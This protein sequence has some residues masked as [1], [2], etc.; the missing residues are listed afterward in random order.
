MKNFFNIKINTNV[1]SG[2]GTLDLIPDKIRELKFKRIGIVVDG[3]LYD[4]NKIVKNFII[5]LNKQFKCIFHKYSLKFEPNY[6]YLDKII[7]Q[8]KKNNKIMVDCIIGIG[9]GSAM[10]TAKALAVI[11]ANNGN[12][13]SFRGFPTDLNKPLPVICVPTTTGTGSELVYNASIIDS[14]SKKKMGINDINNYPILAI[15]DPRLVSDAPLKVVISSTLDALVHAIESF[16]S[17]KSN[18]VTKI[19]IKE[20]IK[21]IF[22]SFPNILKKKSKIDDWINLQWA[23]YFAMAGLSNTSSGPTGALSYFLGANYSVPHGIAGGFF[24]KKILRFNQNKGYYGYAELYDSLPKIKLSKKRISNKSK[25]NE[26]VKYIEMLC[27]KSNIP[28][29]IENFGVK[30]NEIQNFIDF[31]IK[32]SESIK[33]NPVSINKKN[34]LNIIRSNNNSL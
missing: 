26:V 33:N 9:G 18:F 10:D 11:C 6:D 31:S 17:P 21:N 3:N 27:H 16:S 32:A 20:A 29:G 1:F 12:A 8:F 23:A 19:F 13:L 22:L 15:L 14:K 24:L 5:K 4:S 7:N 2:S 34:M 25:S 30:K 28:P